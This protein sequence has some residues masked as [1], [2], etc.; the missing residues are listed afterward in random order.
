MTNKHFTS[1]VLALGLAF[2]ATVAGAAERVP[3][4]ADNAAVDVLFSPQDDISMYLADYIS[5]AQRR[6]WLAGYAFTH[7]DLARAIVQAKERGLD[8]R[9]VLD[10]SE[11][12][13][14]YSGATYFRNAGV[15]VWI[16]ERHAVVQNGRPSLMHHKFVICDEDR[17]GFGSANFTKAAMNGRRGGDALKSNAENFNLFV[18]VPG[19]VKQY[20]TEFERLTAESSRAR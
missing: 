5:K 10:G 1:I 11:A 8:V 4:R 20:A 7:S 18:G 9:V 13:E 3:L 6:V 12:G 14:K 15:A 16:N 19:L 17:V 2:S